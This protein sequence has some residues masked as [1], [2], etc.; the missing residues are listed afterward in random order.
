[1]VGLSR[2]AR[3]TRPQRSSPMVGLSRQ[4]RLHWASLLSHESALI[5]Q[6]G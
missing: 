5:V 4:A 1:M 6:M 2:Q 3:L